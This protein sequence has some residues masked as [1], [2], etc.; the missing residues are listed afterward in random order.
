L[1]AN[2]V[3][4]WRSEMFELSFW[5]ALI[6]GWIK[7]GNIGPE[8]RQDFTVIGPAVKL[9]ARMETLAAEIRSEYR[10]FGS[11]EKPTRNEYLI[12][13][14]PYRKRIFETGFYIFCFGYRLDRGGQIVH[15]PTVFC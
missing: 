12:C 8:N 10:D 11:F 9:A 2:N 7:Y 14:T 3:E 5:L 6:I 4:R 1:A 13:G 15:F